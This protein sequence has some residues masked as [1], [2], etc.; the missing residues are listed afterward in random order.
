MGSVSDRRKR[1]IAALPRPRNRPDSRFGNPGKVN[2][3]SQI[4]QRN[5][6]ARLAVIEH[7][8]SFGADDSLLHRF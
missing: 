7:S 2:R 6:A 8:H 5:A 4:L 1:I 3:F